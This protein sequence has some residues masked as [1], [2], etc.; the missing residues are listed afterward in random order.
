[1]ARKPR[2]HQPLLPFGVA[3]QLDEPPPDSL[4]DGEDHDV[5]VQDHL[6]GVAGAAPGNL[7]PAPP[8]PDASADAEPAGER[9]ESPSSSVDTGTPGHPAGQRQPDSQRSDGTGLKR[10]GG[11]FVSRFRTGSPGFPRRGDGPSSSYAARVKP[12]QK[13]F[14]FEPPS[15]PAPLDSSHGTV[16]GPPDPASCSG[17]LPPGQTHQQPLD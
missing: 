15:D 12:R 9:V 4:T 7:R 10:T 5:S 3:T 1:M 16:I 6:P 11:S 8:A 17:T 14:S 13:L 2:S